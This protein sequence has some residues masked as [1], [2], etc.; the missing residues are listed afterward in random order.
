MLGVRNT[1]RDFTVSVVFWLL[2][3]RYFGC[4][5]SRVDLRVLTIGAIDR[6][7]DALLLPF[8]DFLALDLELYEPRVRAGGEAV[9]RCASGEKKNDGNGERI[10]WFVF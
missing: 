6:F 5:K 2:H 4:V 9:A 7:P 10:P 8:C 3:R 1:R